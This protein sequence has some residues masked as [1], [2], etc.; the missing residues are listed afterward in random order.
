MKDLSLE[1]LEDFGLLHRIGEDLHPTNGYMLLTK[2]PLKYAKIQCALFKGLNRDV[3]IVQKANRNEK[4][5][6]GN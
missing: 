5:N 4:H 1:K 3:L 2:N 6:C